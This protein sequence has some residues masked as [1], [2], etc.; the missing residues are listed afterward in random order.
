MKRLTDSLPTRWVAAGVLTLAGIGSAWFFVGKYT[1][2]HDYTA[3]VDPT[4]EFLRAAQA[5]DSLTLVRLGG[6]PDAV[7]W[8]LAAGRQDPELLAALLRGLGAT[9]VR[10]YANG[11]LVLYTSRGFGT[12]PTAPLAVTFTG[13]P[14]A[15][16]ITHLSAECE[17]RR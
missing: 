5:L 16:R 8:G 17:V 6:S 4:R 1:V 11:A 2:R 12:C 9:D 15:A 10:Q 7:A 3:F 13:V 14:P